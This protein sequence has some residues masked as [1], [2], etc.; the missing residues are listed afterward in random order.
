MWMTKSPMYW[1][2]V[3]GKPNAL[4]IYIASELFG[5]ESITDLGTYRIT[6]PEGIVCFSKTETSVVYNQ[7]LVLN[8]EVS[9]IAS[10]VETIV[11]SNVYVYD[12]M[13]ISEVDCQIFTITGQ[14]VT[15]MNGNLERGVYVVKNNNSAVKVI[16]K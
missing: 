2:L 11:L 16:V 10:S 1:S 7:S 8:Y 12:G 13:I 5:T 3:E 9:D 15:R 4:R 6:I 14:D